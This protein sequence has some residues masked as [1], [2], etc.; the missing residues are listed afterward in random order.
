MV[1]VADDKKGYVSSKPRTGIGTHPEMVLTSPETTYVMNMAQQTGAGGDNQLQI[2]EANSQ[3]TSSQMKKL[4][5]VLQVQ[6]HGSPTGDNALKS[7]FPKSG[8]GEMNSLP[9]E[10][11]SPPP[12]Y[13]FSQTLGVAKLN[14]EED[15]FGDL[16]HLSISPPASRFYQR[17]SSNGSSSSE[18]DSKK[19]KPNLLSPQLTEDPKQITYACDLC[20]QGD[21]TE[22]KAFEDDFWQPTLS[23]ERT[24]QL[25]KSLIKMGNNGSVYKVVDG[26]ETYALKEALEQ[27]STE[28][29]IMRELN[30]TNVV[31]IMGH[32]RE[33]HEFKM[34]FAPD[35]DLATLASK[36]GGLFEDE[37]LFYF[38]Q[39]SNGLVYLHSKRIIHCDL[40]GDNILLKGVYPQQCEVKLADFGNACVLDE[41]YEHSRGTKEFMA[42]EVSEGK[43]C[44]KA[45]D[46][47]SVGCCM[48]ESL[49]GQ[50]PR[51]NKQGEVEVP[52]GIDI[53][54]GLEQIIDKCLETDQV[55]RPSADDLWDELNRLWLKQMNDNQF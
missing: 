19:D 30:H 13:S 18:D 50:W 54:D 33:F 28:V 3:R 16:D 39:V 29:N 6:D 26:K 14:D 10:N 21:S 35:G 40:K 8:I 4:Y 43:P 32:C 25:T 34:E 41:G 42:P 15:Y 5:P 44:S 48:V 55:L 24:P 23:N 53:S 22:M 1:D 17:S 46:V 31:K 20:T 52:S 49:S 37:V 47:Y 27:N 38:V 51:R 12:I 7:S 45:S 9:L 2:D 36:N 11:T